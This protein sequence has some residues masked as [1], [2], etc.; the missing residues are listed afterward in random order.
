MILRNKEIMKKKR[1]ENY[2]MARAQL[3][4]P[5]VAISPSL[6]VNGAARRLASGFS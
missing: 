3:L 1:K 6:M 5:N 4:T 2:S